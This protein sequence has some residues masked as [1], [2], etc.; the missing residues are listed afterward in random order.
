MPAEINGVPFK[1]ESHLK[2]YAGNGKRISH[3]KDIVRLDIL[4]KEGGI[5]SD[6]DVVWLRTPIEY[7]HHTAA[8]AFSNKSYKTLCNCVMMSEAGHEGMR[9]Y[10]EWITGMYPPK[11]YWL[12]ANPYKIWKERTDITFLERPTIFGKKKWNTDSTVNW[13]DTEGAFCIHLFQS[14]EHPICGEVIDYVRSHPWSR[15]DG[16]D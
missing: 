13:K 16:P 1:D 4:Y 10:K 11:K 3:V 15:E 12:P 9:A 2:G 14:M 5:Y 7:L 6:L 8:I